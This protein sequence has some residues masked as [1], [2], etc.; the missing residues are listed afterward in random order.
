MKIKICGITNVENAVFC[1]NKGVDA[2]G[3]FLREV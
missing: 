3:L 2:L 1:E